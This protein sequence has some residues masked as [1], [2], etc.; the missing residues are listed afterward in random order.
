M[1]DSTALRKESSAR[2]SDE[3]AGQVRKRGSVIWYVLL[4]VLAV[5]GSLAALLIPLLNQV[6]SP[7]LQVGQVAPEE[8]RAPRSYTYSSEVLTAQRRQAEAA[9]VL[10][11]YTAPDT[12]IA[13]QQRERLRAALDFIANVRADTL[14]TPEQKQED[15]NS[16]EYIR[17]DQITA[18][19]VL[20]LGEARWQIV[21]QEATVVLEK[22]MSAAVRQDNLEA[23]RS[24]ALGLVNLSVPEDLAH[25]V[26]NLAASF[27][28]PNSQYSE[29]ATQTAR[30][31]ASESV[32]PVT[33]SFVANQTIVQR[34][35]VISDADL[36]ALHQFSLIQPQQRWQDYVSP[37]VLVVLMGTFVLFYLIR[38]AELVKNFRS[39]ALITVLF[40]IYLVVA[41]LLI[42]AHTVIPYAF[43]VAAYTLTT[44]V[45]F[46]TELAMVTSLPLAILAAYNLSNS[47]DL[48]IFY[49]VGSLLGVLALGRAR[50]MSAFIWA[51]VAVAVSGAAVIVAYRLMLSSTDWIGL[52]TLGGAALFNGLVTASLTILL[53]SVLAQFL[54]VMTPMQLIDLSRPDHPLLQL[55]LHEAP[56][57]YQHSLQLANLAE[58]A[59]E[60]IG[61]D[62]LVTR[63][64]ALY[65]DAG[66]AVNPAFFIENQLPGFINPHDDLEPSASATVI[67][68]HVA[69][70]LE[71]ARKYRLPGRI[72]DFIS[73]HHG[74]MQTRY[75]Y[76]R[77]VQ[78]VSGD[79]SQVDQERF[80]YPGPRP[81]SRETAILMLADGCEAIVR[82][83]HPRGEDEL[84]T[85]IKGV[86]EDRLAQGQLDGTSLTLNDLV[87]IRESF[88]ATLRGVFHPRVNYPK[89]E[90][91]R[92]SD[93]ASSLIESE[94]E[95]TRP[96]VDRGASQVPLT[97]AQSTEIQA[98]PRP[99]PPPLS[100][101]TG[102]GQQAGSYVSAQTNG[103][104]AGSE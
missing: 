49:V 58:Q 81:Q 99:E 17:L 7:T 34:G 97:A 5:A 83:E 18:Q 92:R 96:V 13:R 63:V 95:K 46:G 62:A 41:R 32:A 44:A 22:M 35:Q 40:I 68:R 55:I 11:I 29:S 12:G 15:L 69:D 27:V 57:T 30:Q 26:A 91:A 78:A 74:T 84:R 37:A 19:A 86:I 33:R 67:I 36:E 61:A 1:N 14:A 82:A 98:A 42:P 102:D 43:P 66:K 31:K 103:T 50:R 88:V 56:G 47:L 8:Y 101:P 48:T 87:T 21:Q 28:I 77:A 70:G 25:W 53:V 72:R 38:Q 79:E 24:S 100:F 16:L 76:V 80:R 90:T 64:G 89:L 75:Q 51:G 73:E 54:S 39:I 6:L 93:T 4:A 59:A 94:E 65:H 60:H 85:L 45:L 10:V 71:L 20:T 23:V 9:A 2:G 52:V 3:R 104:P